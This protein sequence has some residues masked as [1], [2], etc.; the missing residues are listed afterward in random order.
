MKQREQEQ[1]PE[2]EQEQ[3]QE[4]TMVTKWSSKEEEGV[5]LRYNPPHP[6]P[7]Y[8]DEELRASIVPFNHKHSQSL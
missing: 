6:S 8:T 3:E 7:L 5:L 1:E 2:Q 4:Q